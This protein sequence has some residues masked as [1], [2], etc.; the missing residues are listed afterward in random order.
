M[1]P[2]AT[3]RPSGPPSPRLPRPTDH[4][5]EVGVADERR[6]TG[7]PEH[8]GQ[9]A[10]ESPVLAVVRILLF[11]PASCKR[12][13]ERGPTPSACLSIRAI[14]AGPSWDAGPRPG[15]LTTRV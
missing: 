4:D 14:P 1:P 13:G 10:L 6:C 12:R 5:A 15:A 2:T 3:T 9:R 11:G 8:Q 7:A